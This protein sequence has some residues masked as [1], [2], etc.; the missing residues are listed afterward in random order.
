MAYR[1]SYDLDTDSMEVVATVKDGDS[2]VETERYSPVG[3][4]EEIRAKSDLYGYSKLLQDRA[5]S[6][7]VGPE[8][9]KGMREVDSQL[10]G[11][12]WEKERSFSP[13]TV[14]LLEEA[15]ARV[16]GIEIA[17]AQK[18]LAQ[19]EKDVREQIAENAAV[20][21][22]M[23]TIAREREARGDEGVDLSSLI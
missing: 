9:I 19:Y 22:A 4:N 18:S 1:M 2:I 23:A 11:G 10:K 7:A 21:E 8:R 14:S 12:Q 13:R 20:K 15:V 16:Q 5:N 17:V 3:L 6:C